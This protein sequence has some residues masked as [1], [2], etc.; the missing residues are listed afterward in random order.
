MTTKHKKFKVFCI[1]LF[2]ISMIFIF[3]CFITTKENLNISEKIELTS[4]G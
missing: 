3:L 1:S 4:Q 2:V